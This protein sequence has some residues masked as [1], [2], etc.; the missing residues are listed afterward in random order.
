MI[1]WQRWMLIFILIREK[2]IRYLVMRSIVSWVELSDSYQMYSS[3]SL[4]LVT[5]WVIYWQFLWDNLLQHVAY[6]GLVSSIY[7]FYISIYDS[8]RIN[9]GA[10]EL[11]QLFWGTLFHLLNFNPPF[12]FFFCFFFW[13]WDHAYCIGKIIVFF[14]TKTKIE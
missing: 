12:L 7:L 9:N 3:L 1:R 2:D 6:R 4:W 8:I 11:S 13:V 10:C 5:L 14:L